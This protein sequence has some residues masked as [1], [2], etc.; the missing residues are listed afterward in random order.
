MLS[1]SIGQQ[2]FVDKSLVR[3][4]QNIRIT[5]ID[6][7]FKNKPAYDP[8]ALGVVA[9]GV[10]I[11]IVP[12]AFDAPNFDPFGTYPTARLEYSDIHASSDATIPSQFRFTSPALV[13]TDTPYAILIAY[14]RSAAFTLW[15][16]V[17]DEYLVGSTVKSS[18]PS[19]NFI[20]KMFEYRSL[21]TGPINENTDMV[22]QGLGENWTPINNTTLKLKIT[23]ARYYVD[24]VPVS[25]TESTYVPASVN[26]IMSANSAEFNFSINKLEFIAYD[27]DSSYKEAFVGSQ[28]AF[29]ETV[30]YPG[31]ANSTGGQASVSIRVNQ[32][33]TTIIANNT[34]P[35]GASFNWNT[36]FP[37]LAN[38]KFIVIESND[39]YDV[40]KVVSI[41][42]NTVLLVDEPITIS[43]SAARFMITAVGYVDSFNKGSPFGISENFLVLAASSANST[44]RFVNNSIE[45]VQPVAAGSGY[46]NSDVIFVKG[47]E[48]V[49]GKV[50]GGYKA[51]GNLVTNGS[52]GI[53]NIR[54]SN[55]GAG[56]VNTAAMS[57]V[58]A[59]STNLSNTTGNTSSGTGA[60]FSYTIG[61]TIKTDMR[62]NVFKKIRVVN[63]DMSQLIPS[64]IVT[65]PPGSDVTYSL[66]TQYYNINSAN[67]FAGKEYYVNNNGPDFFDISLFARN[68]M[69][70]DQIPC[71][72]SRS[73]E[74]VTLYANGS[75][76]NVANNLNTTSNNIVLHVNTI[77]NNDFNEVFFEN[78]PSVIFSSY[79]INND[80]TNEHTDSGNA[81]ARRISNKIPFTRAAEDVLVGCV[82]YR[83]PNTDIKMYARVY[84]SAD[85]EA[86]DDKDWTLLEQ[87]DGIGLYSSPN[88]LNDYVELTYSLP[89]YPNT[90]ATLSGTVTTELS[91]TI[92]VGSGTTWSS[93][94]S[95]NL[96]SGDLIR[97]YSPLFPNNHVVAVV[98][99]VANDSQ[100]TINNVIANSGLV[101]SGFMIDKMAYKHQAY[102][103]IQ[104]SNICRYHNSDMSV[105]DGYDILAIKIIF[106]SDTPHKIPRVDG[107]GALGTTA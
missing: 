7:F 92:I 86:F 48:D 41:A 14:D 8:N 97:I 43:N 4:A 30:F 78:S 69:T 67:T 40:R 10:T 99:S 1:F 58:I 64:L 35:N 96:V 32:G 56:Y 3:N 72:M 44:V 55:C 23:C 46:S 26:S 100:I 25:N 37:S 38:E 2:I 66:G 11:K 62:P 6:L 16:N 88:D 45:A 21:I 73:N 74:F 52:G 60:S 50:V 82:A 29:Q 31:G 20:G 18:G 94:T 102:N 49:A 34:L 81:W 95:A 47:Y 22:G 93:N 76:N 77:S 28:Y 83:P 51:V 17:E 80:Y 101:G 106:L 105:F 9:P 12:V 24:G 27:H 63:M 98:Q 79:V 13:N 68:Y 42:N 85:P 39:V 36:I 90:A 57:V 70:N 65:V 75:V 84:N 15:K 59:N 87:R 53:T 91:N 33:N 19:G 89:Q 61:G 71:F 54:L 103:N 5:T 107:I 104:N